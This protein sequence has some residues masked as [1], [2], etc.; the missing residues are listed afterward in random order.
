MLAQ[1]IQSRKSEFDGI[2][3]I[4]AVKKLRADGYRCP[5][6]P[7]FARILESHAMAKL[8]FKR[9]KDAPPKQRGLRLEH[10]AEHTAEHNKQLDRIEENQAKILAGL[11]KLMNCWECEE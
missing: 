7:A 2:G 10:T 11:E 3:F 1:R 9:K 6:A 4:A 5:E 8:V